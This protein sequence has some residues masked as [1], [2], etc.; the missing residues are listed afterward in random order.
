MKSFH[1]KNINKILG[2]VER[3]MGVSIK[4]TKLKCIFM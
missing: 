4:P 3:F 1:L 2:I